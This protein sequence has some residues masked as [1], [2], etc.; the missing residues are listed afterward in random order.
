MKEIEMISSKEAQEMSQKCRQCEQ[1]QS[2]EDH[3][4]DDTPNSEVPVVLA[5]RA[6]AAAT[7]ARLILGCR[8]SKLL[9]L[10]SLE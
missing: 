10:S 6:A 7:E 1:V 4:P 3:S 9:R 2:Q 8:L 5:T